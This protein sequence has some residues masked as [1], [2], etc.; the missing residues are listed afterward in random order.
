MKFL[1][2][3]K[4]LLEQ[5]DKA[6]ILKKISNL[7]INLEPYDDLRRINIDGITLEYEVM[8]DSIYIEHIGVPKE[9]RKHGFA[10]ALLSKFLSAT[11]KKNVPVKLMVY[12]TDDTTEEELVSI[13]KKLGFEVTGKDAGNKKPLMTRK[14]R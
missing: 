2:T 5:F 3:Y 4:G 13:Y 11:D 9:M 1:E 12:P 10:K 7:N 8:D 14:S 6:N